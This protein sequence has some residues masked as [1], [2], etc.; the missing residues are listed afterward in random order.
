M[1]ALRVGTESIAHPFNAH[2][3][4]GDDVK[5]AG[6]YIVGLPCEKIFGG[7]N[8]AA[9]LGGRDT[10]GRAA[11]AL[12]GARHA[13]AYLNEYQRAGRIAHHQID[14]A[15]LAA[16]I[17]GDH[18]QTTRLQIAQGAVFTGLAGCSVVVWHRNG[19]RRVHLQFEATDQEKFS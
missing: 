7:G 6:R 9:L 16:I 19:L 4:D 11:E 2:A 13:G 3:V 5:T 18:R 10:R 1:Q 14:L 17:A 15:A 8:Q 12:R